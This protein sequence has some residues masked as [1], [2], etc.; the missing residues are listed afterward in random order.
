MQ[1]TYSPTHWPA[2]FAA[3]VLCIAG[4]FAVA[5]CGDDDD[6]LTEAERF[7]V[8]RT[9][10]VDED[11]PLDKETDTRLSCL[12]NFK[13][14]YCG[15]TPC[16]GDADCPHGSTCITHDDGVNYCFLVCVD[17]ERDCNNIRD[18][19]FPNNCS[20]NITHVDNPNQ[21][22]ACVPPSG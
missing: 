14:G 3:I 8:G 19:L 9:C 4:P 11:C 6:E 22:K 1:R 21:P 7:G 2:R 15:K 12:T 13:G 17:K 20:A 16:S 5:S 18:P 10:A